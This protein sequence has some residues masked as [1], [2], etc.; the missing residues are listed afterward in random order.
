M[1]WVENRFFF[2]YTEALPYMY[3]LLQVEFAPTLKQL[4]S[5]VGGIGSHLTY[6]ISEIQRLLTILTEKIST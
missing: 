3:N 6:S 5:I 1:F 4:A 2:N